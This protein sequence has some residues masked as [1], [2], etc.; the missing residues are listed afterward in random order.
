[1]K[2][3][4]TRTAHFRRNSSGSLRPRRHDP[5][6]QTDLIE[7]RRLVDLELAELRQAIALRAEK[8]P[9]GSEVA[10]SPEQTRTTM[11]R[12]REIIKRR[13]DNRLDLLSATGEATRR[14]MKMGPPDDLDGRVARGWGGGVRALFLPG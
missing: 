10:A 5:A 11:D 1:M 12:I 13:H 14:E 8:G 7:L 4:R 6:G 2:P 3:S 9:A